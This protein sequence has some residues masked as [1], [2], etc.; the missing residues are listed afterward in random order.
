MIHIRVDDGR[1]LYPELTM[2][3]P[4]CKSKK[5]YIDYY[6]H[7]TCN[8][9]GCS[10]DDTRGRFMSKYRRAKKIKRRDMAK[11][12]N[13]K[14]NTLTRYEFEEPSKIVFNKF[15]GIIRLDIGDKK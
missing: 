7:A 12:L 4:T 14:P 10:S 13:I 2:D 15:V 11:M 8:V 3:C 1:G 6:D 5:S 9:C